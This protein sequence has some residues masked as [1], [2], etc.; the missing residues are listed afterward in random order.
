MIGIFIIILI[1][2]IFLIYIFICNQITFP[3]SAGK[4]NQL[5]NMIQNIIDQN[6]GKNTGPSYPLIAVMV[7]PRTKNLI[8]TI[9]LYLRN[10]P[11]HVHFYIFHGNKNK[12]LLKTKFNKE[13][14]Q[15]KISLVDLGVDNLN[16]QEYS[17]LLLS[18][19]FWEILP[20][21]NILIF[22]TDSV[23]CSQSKFQMEN[24]IN[25]DFIGA[26]FSKTINNLLHFYFLGKGKWINYRNFMNGGLSF[27]KKSKM[28]ELIEKYPWDG[29]IPEDIWCVAHLHKLNANLPDIETARMFSFE[30]ENLF[31]TPFGLHKPRKEFETLQEICPEVKQIETIPSHTDYRNLF[32][33]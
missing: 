13:L 1:F 2:V 31:E 15:N 18:K 5:E 30:S 23:I 29:L 9:H 12:E 4:S 22:Q 32:L 26:P 28:I 10:L 6:T 25:Y 8:E 16:I 24:F 21:E 17:G 20:S 33:L 14:I 19:S 11:E 7:E 27:R 3:L